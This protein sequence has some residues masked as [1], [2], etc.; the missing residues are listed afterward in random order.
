MQ[1][2]LLYGSGTLAASLDDGTRVVPAATP[3]PAPADIAAAVRDAIG[4]LRGRVGPGARVTVAFDDPAVFTMMEPDPR[5]VAIPAILATL[6]DAG[7]AMRDVTLL[8]AN[9]LHCRWTRRELGTILGAPFEH[10][11]PL[12]R[13]VCHDAEDR[14]AL[15]YL[16]ETERG[17]EVE[18]NRAVLDSDFFVYLSIPLTPFNGGWKSVGV[19]LSSFRSIRHHHRPF[20]SSG[21]SIMDARKSAF[22]KLLREIG[23]VIAARLAVDG[24]SIL[25]VELVLSNTT[26]RGVAGV[27]AG[28]TDDA[29]ARALELLRRQM[30]VEVDGQTDALVIGLPD[31]DPYSRFTVPN[32]LLL[33]NLGCAYTFGLY[34]E[35]PLVREG[36]F[37]VLATPMEPRFDDLR[38][39][40]YREFFTRVLAYTRDPF[41]AWELFA[42]DFANRR[43][44]LH[45][46]RFGHGFHGAH[47]FFMWNSTLFPRRHLG[48]IFVAGARDPD[49]VRHLGF[50]PFPS[51]EAALS[52][53]GARLG[54]APSVT[55]LP[56]EP[57]RIARV[58][59]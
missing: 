15:V 16:G 54:R 47:P 20:P 50:E 58:R 5:T 59:T 34:E 46:Y 42:D 24:K 32:P 33:T 19:G 39:P 26:P 31:I 48:G 18:V 44:Y 10:F 53:A 21:Q 14:D 28:D 13:L 6:G 38:H 11:W 56:L 55:V 7:V 51:V 22:P 37:L 12:H 35:R 29:H 57:L 40:S 36:G 49:V 43:E 23:R 9:A 17:L 2:D 25:Q 41:E 3:L 30:V 4:D 27:F 8:C 52:A 45:A 1:V